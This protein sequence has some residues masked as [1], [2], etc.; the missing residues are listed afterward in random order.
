VYCRIKKFEIFSF[1]VSYG[2]LSSRSFHLWR[3]EFTAVFVKTL[4][5]FV[6]YLNSKVKVKQ[7][8][9]RPGQALRFPG[10]WGS[11]ISRQSALEGGEVVRPTHRPCL[12]QR[13]YSWYSFLS[14]GSIATEMV[15]VN[16]KFQWHHRDSNP[17]VAQCLNELRHRGPY[18]NSTVYISSYVLLDIILPKSLQIM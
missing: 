5:Y 2:N 9:Y 12:P 3:L 17:S 14:E 11:Q 8:H 18:L 4:T 10:G 7:S 15:Y 6:A 16:E 1:L 13:K